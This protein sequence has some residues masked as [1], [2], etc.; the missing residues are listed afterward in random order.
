MRIQR[1]DRRVRDILG[2]RIASLEIV[3]RVSLVAVKMLFF[4]GRGM[5]GGK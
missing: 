3:D 1:V 2:T 5:R 4:C